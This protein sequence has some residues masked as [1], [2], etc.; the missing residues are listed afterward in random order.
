MLL[1][2]RRSILLLRR[3]G[4][5]AAGL[6]T[7]SGQKRWR[8]P[9]G[10]QLLRVVA[11]R[12]R[13]HN[14]RMAS[15]DCMDVEDAVEAAA[16]SCSLAGVF[17][18]E[19]VRQR[20][21]ASQDGAEGVGNG[22]EAPSANAAASAGACSTEGASAGGNASAGAG[23]ADAGE[24]GGAEVEA[25]A[26]AA[27]EPQPKP[28]RQ[29]VLLPSVFEGRPPV[30][31]FSYTVACGAEQRPLDR[32]IYC[33]IDGPRLFYSHT[34]AVHEYNA[35]INIMRQGGL[36]RVKAESQKWMLLWSN[37]PPPEVLQ[38]MKPTQKTNHFPGSF[39]L[40]RKDLLWKNISRMQRRFGIRD[41]NITPPAY[42]LPKATLAWDAAR[43]RQPDA[44]WIWKPCSQSCG[45]GIRVLSSTLKPE[46]ARDLSR[47]RG[48][49]QKYIPNPLTIDGYKF[50]M[51]IYVVVLSYDPL[52]VYMNDEGLV[53]LATQKY[54]SDPS[55]LESRTMH[56]TNYSVNKLSPLF[57]QNK[58]GREDCIRRRRE[59]AAEE[60]GRQAI[61]MEQGLQVGE[62]AAASGGDA[63]MEDGE[64]QDNGAHVSKWSLTE[65]R[66]NF[67]ER[68]LDYELMIS[69]MKDVIIKTLIAVE[70][71]IQ[72]EWC[73]ALENRDMGWLARGPAGAHS[74]SS[75]T[76]FEM[77]GF[78]ILVDSDLKPWLLEVNI[79]P[80]LSSGSPLDKRIKTKLVADTLTLAGFRP[81]SNVWKR[82]AGS[83][84]KPASD[85]VGMAVDE[86]EDS[87][88]PVYL[89]ED[90]A[91]RAARLA[92]A[93][94][95][96]DAVAQFDE[97][98]WEI[99]LE[100]HDQ[101]M[102]CGGLER[103][104]PAEDSAKYGMFFEEESYFNMVL[105]RFYE[106]GGGALFGPA[107]RQVV[108][109][110]VPR[111]INFSP[112]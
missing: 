21:R 100:A 47:K 38:A 51:R 74:D 75:S 15:S 29:L 96:L 59:T 93:E 112:T 46:E 95:P 80:S 53:R 83:M 28:K 99:V 102:R 1:G 37:H 22:G 88:G 42:V 27:A 111:Q 68:G 12:A 36:Y 55:T 14:A 105:R 92:A 103:I 25:G 43:V 69:R 66:Q 97:L 57:V 44:I 60:Q 7:K 104:F 85:V 32:A 72:A 101:D 54:S 65:L 16:G 61:A 107:G 110:W 109:P 11:A 9:R 76:C 63:S 87:C 39:N 4:M 50:D 48:I 17:S 35:V 49:V 86:A 58:D 71:S 34:D 8:G 106:A 19:P 89:P 84:A 26:G 81:P 67:A 10:T 62:A 98:A 30:L 52:K 73:K 70:P 56:L 45:R 94:T 31:F 78:D 20:R 5:C 33:D 18:A 23:A 108:P 3:R 41:C 91:R 79:C 82:Y 90:M 6:A 24:G 77:Y 40:G 64:Q 2:R 13:R